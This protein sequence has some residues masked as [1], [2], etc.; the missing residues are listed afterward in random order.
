MGHKEHG[1]IEIL[2][3][4]RRARAGDSKREIARATGI[5]RKTIS[6]Y[7]AIAHEC[8]LTPISIQDELHVIALAVF[9]KIHLTGKKER[10]SV[11]EETLAPH[12]ETI[13][14]WLQQEELTLTKVHIKLKRMGVSV[15][16][17]ALYRYSCKHLDFGG[18]K[19]AP[20]AWQRPLQAKWPRWTSDGSASCTI[21]Q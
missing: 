16:Y 7:L 5:D 6:K 3:I 15:D 1:M 2:D 20:Y 10:S 14:N 12:K 18:V 8:G 21:R 17:N 4:L 11:N 13:K 19:N 9:Q